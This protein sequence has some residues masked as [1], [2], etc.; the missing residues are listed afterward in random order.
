MNLS[1]ID[2]NRNLWCYT[3]P[4]GLVVV[5]RIVNPKTRQYVTTDIVTVPWPVARVALAVRDKRKR[6]RAAQERSR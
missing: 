6:P 4:E 2:I 1:P 3:E 5:H